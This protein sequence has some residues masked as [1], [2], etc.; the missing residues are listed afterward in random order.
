MPNLIPLSDNKQEMPNSFDKLDLF[1]VFYFHE[2]YGDLVSELETE[3]KYALVLMT[4]KF[5]FAARKAG[6]LKLNEKG[7]SIEAGARDDLRDC[8]INA[9]KASQTIVH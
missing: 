8:I 1:S 7:F 3:V 2:E 9:I 5:L 6:D 4:Y